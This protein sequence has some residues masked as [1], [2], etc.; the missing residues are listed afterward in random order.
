[1][2]QSAHRYWTERLTNNQYKKYTKEIEKEIINVYKQA[3]LSIL[4]V[5][6]Q[7]WLDMLT[8]GEISI[9]SLYTYNR[10]KQ[11][12][13]VINRELNSLGVTV[14]ETIN[15]SLFQAY[16]DSFSEATA[17]L[18]GELDPSYSQFNKESINS[19]VNAN[20]KGAEWSSRIWNNQDKLR[21]ILNQYIVDSVVLGRDVRKVSKELSKRMEVSLSDSKRIVRTET[22]R[23]LNDGCINAAIDRGYTNVEWLAEKDDRL[24][25]EC[26][27]MNGKI[28]SIHHAPRILHPNCRCTIL[29]VVE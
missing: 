17:E 15:N 1:M 13:D 26:S 3:N 28:L 29:P 14:T 21:V 24:C 10:Y 20:F 19:I 12:Q 16:I 9:S 23:V 25:D 22:M 6:R 18:G 5:I 4:N 11:I 8:D 7:I 27:E 2:S